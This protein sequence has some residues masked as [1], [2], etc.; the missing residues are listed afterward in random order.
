[1]AQ[2]DLKKSTKGNRHHKMKKNRFLR[3]FLL[4]VVV[5]VFNSSLVHAADQGNDVT[6]ES[7][8]PTSQES[9]KES[10]PN[11]ASDAKESMASKSSLPQPMPDS[12]PG[13]LTID[14]KDA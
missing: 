7:P 12:T 3:L 10:P 9:S 1:M 11:V 6:S 13:N 8:E 4:A 2:K 5:M 14:F